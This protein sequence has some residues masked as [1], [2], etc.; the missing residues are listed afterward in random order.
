VIDLH[1]HLLP[2]VD[3][4]SRSVAQSV[5]VLGRFADQGVTAV[6]LTP[7]LLASDAAAGRPADHD[8][9]FGALLAAA[10]T[11][12]RLHRGAEIMLD[13][14]LPAIVARQRS[15]TLNATQFVL[16]EFNRMVTFQAA[17]AALTHVVEIGLTPVL[18]HPER[19]ACCTPEV[20]RRWRGMGAVMQVDGST[21]ATSRGRGER[22]RALV[23][24]GLADIL[25]GDNHGDDR[26]LATAR[27]FLAQHDGSAQAQLLL[28]LN[29]AAILAGGALEEVPPLPIRTNILSRLRNLLTENDQ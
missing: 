7:H 6:C 4:G 17:A 9:A 19:Y 13:R 23:A 12:P 3:D 29:P 14:P 16:V 27:E 10:P 15:V 26:T 21:L 28:E 1:N 24:E 22:A 2:G 5:R 11:S 8:R 25:A 20:V 18:A